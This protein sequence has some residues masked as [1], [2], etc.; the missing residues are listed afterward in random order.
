[1]EPDR[2]ATA[3]LVLA[4]GRSTRMG[5]DKA[6]LPW[7]GSTL[8]R[9]VVGLLER[10]V[11]GPVVVA[12]AAGQSLPAL[13]ERIEVLD[14]PSPAGGPLVGLAAGL[15]HL[16]AHASAVV[17]CGT[18]QPS[19]HPA[20]LRRL[21]EARGTHD[22]AALRLDGRL[23][24]LPAAYATAL[25]PAAAELAALGAGPS[26]L[27]RR[28]AVRALSPADVLR[29]AAGGAQPR[30]DADD[31]AEVLRDLDDEAAYRT[32]LARPLPLVDV[33]LPG[34]DVRR[35]RAGTAGL[36]LEAAGVPW[37]P[38]DL[39]L[40]RLRVTDPLVPLVEGDVLDVGHSSG[41]ATP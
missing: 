37:A 2:D 29:G 30:G 33:R 34:G 26:A 27:L 36:A 39:H 12:R 19:V 32:A 35:V 10:A 13:P 25:A 8:L 38:G 11:E 7:H 18:D 24:P 6:A 5:R 3:G 17:A 15:A 16:S 1:V 28:C 40:G 20:L 9:H 31:L 21:G 41:V 4:G 22:A 23:Q 14:D